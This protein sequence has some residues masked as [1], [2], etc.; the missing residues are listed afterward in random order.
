MI[1]YSIRQLEKISGIKA[2][3][4]RIWE[5]RYNLF[6]PERTQT[7]IRYYDN[8]HLK[9]I[10][11]ISTL[12]QN[13]YKISKISTLTDEEVAAEIL[14]VHDA[15]ASEQEK[16]EGQVN[17]L[18]G[19]CME[20]NQTSFEEIFQACVKSFGFVQTIDNVLY[21]LFNRIGVL[22]Q[23]S[24]INPA[25]EHFLS[26]LARQ[27]FFTAIDTMHPPGNKQ[28]SFLL[29]L[30]QN[31]EHEIGLLYCNYLL[32]NASYQTV[33]LGQRLPFENLKDAMKVLDATH[34]IFF[35]VTQVPGKEII[36]YVEN[37]SRAFPSKKILLCG[38]NV[39]LKVGKP[40][41]NVTL[42]RTPDEF[43]KYLAELS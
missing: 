1:N 38:S 17:N 3:T 23:S 33:Y 40:P 34:L 43:R 28:K 5:K 14:K 15:H 2:H 9:K 42:F 39:L 4:I 36:K 35:M 8:S 16:Y 29:F 27:K 37:V 26:N 22:W 12:L 7:N 19:A 13:G 18:I 24:R 10:L 31:E 30:P 41:S 25:Q 32:R 6:S 21:P 20:F 11:N